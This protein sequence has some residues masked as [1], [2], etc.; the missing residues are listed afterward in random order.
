MDRVAYAIANDVPAPVGCVC[1]LHKGWTCTGMGGHVYSD[2][3][4]HGMCEMHG[5]KVDS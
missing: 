2:W 5:R 3:S 1:T 4:E